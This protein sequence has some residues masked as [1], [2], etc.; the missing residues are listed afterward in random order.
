MTRAFI[1]SGLVSWV[2][3]SADIA[4]V[5]V[6]GLVAAGIAAWLGAPARSSLLRTSPSRFEQIPSEGYTRD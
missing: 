3:N 4:V 6:F 2:P 1:E 5:I